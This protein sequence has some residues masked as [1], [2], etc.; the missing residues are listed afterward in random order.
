MVVCSV[1]R[2]ASG[3][4]SYALPRLARIGSLK[5]LRSRASDALRAGWLLVWA[6]FWAMFAI[7]GVPAWT[8]DWAEAQLL[9]LPGVD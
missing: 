9:R 1:R 7:V 5:W 3:V 6:I 4:S 2:S 8:P